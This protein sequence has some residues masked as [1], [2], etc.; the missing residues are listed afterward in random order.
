[1]SR[2]KRVSRGL[3][4]NFAECI[5]RFDMDGESGSILESTTDTKQGK[6]RK[7]FN[8]IQFNSI[9]YPTRLHCHPKQIT[10]NELV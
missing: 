4:S 8:S 5:G 3:F 9:Q 2:E 6:A 1:M 7:Q 10:N